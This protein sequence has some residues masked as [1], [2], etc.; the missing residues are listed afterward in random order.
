MNILN[1][2]IKHHIIIHFITSIMQLFINKF[3]F[4]H[5]KYLRQFVFCGDIQYKKASENFRSLFFYLLFNNDINDLVRDNDHLNNVLTF[6]KFLNLFIVC[7][8]FF[9]FV[10]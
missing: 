2:S 5:I 10:F 4:L 8:Q 9:E 3:Q 1:I 7:S 6:D